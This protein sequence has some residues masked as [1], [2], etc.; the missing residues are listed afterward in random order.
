M[1]TGRD[2]GNKSRQIGI[3]RR[4]IALICSPRGLAAWLVLAASAVA[5]PAAQA[6]RVVAGPVIGDVTSSTARVWFQLSTS[7]TVRIR[8]FDVVSGRQVSSISMGVQGPPPFICDAAMNGLQPN[9]NY[10]IKAYVGHH[11]L[12]L[13][14]INIHT[15][16]PRKDPSR[17]TVAFG[18]CVHVHYPVQNTIWNAIANTQCQAMIFAGNV[19]YLPP[20]L[21]QFPVTHQQTYWRLAYHD[22]H[23]RNFAPWQKLLTS[24]A[25]YATWDDRDYGPRHSNGGFVFKPEALQIFQRYWPNPYYGQAAAPG[26]YC[27]FTIGD[28]QFFLLDDRMYRAGRKKAATGSMLGGV[29]LAWLKKRLAKS[30]AN[31]NIIIDGEPMVPNYTQSGAWARFAP[32]RHAFIHWIFEHGVR[33]VIFLSGHRQFGELTCRPPQPGK[34]NEYPLYELTSSSLNGALAKPT[35]RHAKNPWRVGQAD[36]NNNF[37]L[38]HFAGP[39]NNRH[40]VLELRSATGRRVLTKALFAGALAGYLPTAPRGR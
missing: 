10:S 26:T 1:R 21:K 38:L 5:A 30:H 32:E 28:A 37:G 4:S 14:E 18:S 8:C 40:V 3:A 33:G 31:F 17:F 16:P 2:A 6:V 29:Q 12:N 20:T 15:A 35:A 25:V 13:R 34:V 27:R 9:R 7:D 39:S 19:G 36:F 22:Q 24:T 23:V 11:R